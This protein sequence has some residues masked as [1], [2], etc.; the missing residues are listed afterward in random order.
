MASHLSIIAKVPTIGVAKKPLQVYY[1]GMEEESTLR[2]RIGKLNK[3]GDAMT[4]YN[5]T[6]Q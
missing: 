5:D 4:L 6:V 3:K 1:R 2:E